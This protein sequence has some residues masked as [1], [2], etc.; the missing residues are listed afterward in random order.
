[1]LI[2]TGSF[3][4]ELEDALLEDLA[5]SG[6]P[7][8]IVPLAVVVP[9][10]HVRRYLKEVIT[11]ELGRSLLGVHLLTF[12][13]LALRMAQEGGEHSLEPA[14][15]RALE[16]LIALLLGQGD[17]PERLR[18]LRETS[19]G[20]RALRRTLRALGEARV[21]PDPKAKDPLLRLY[22]DYER[23][24]RERGLGTPA[25]VT[26]RAT[27][28]SSK[29]PFLASLRHLF[30]YGFYDLTQVQ[31]DFLEAVAAARPAT[32]YFPLRR[33]HPAFR[34]AERFL[35]RHLRGTVQA[36][37]SPAPETGKRMALASALERLF[38]E[39]VPAS[40]RKVPLKLIEV[41]GPE[42]ELRAV[43]K[44]IWRRVEEEGCR[45]DQIGVVARTLDPYL[46]ELDRVFREHAIPY[47]SSAVEPAG[48]HPKVRGVRLLAALL[49]GRFLREEVIGL[50]GSPFLKAET[51][52]GKGVSVRPDRW[53]AWTR[54]LGV[55]EGEGDWERLLRRA[56]GKGK[57]VGEEPLSLEDL[58]SLSRAVGFLMKETERFPR[59]GGWDIFVGRFEE[60]LLKVLDLDV[61]N[62]GERSASLRDSL[63]D[64][65]RSLRAMGQ[66]SREASRGEFLAALDRSLAD[67]A[68]PLGGEEG[69]RVLDAMAARSLKFRR[70]FVLGM[71]EKAFPRF[72]REDPF[73]RDGLRRELARRH[74]V[75]IPLQ[76]EGYDEEKL[77]FYLLLAG[78]AEEVVLCAQR[79][80]TEGKPLVP[81]WYRDELL[82]AVGSEVPV[83]SVPRRMEDWLGG[84]RSGYAPYLLTPREGRIQH[85]LRGGDPDS[86]LPHLRE[87]LR[88]VRELDAPDRHLGERDGVVGPLPWHAETFRGRGCSPTALKRY[89]EC[90]FQ[91]FARSV[92]ELEPLEEPERHLALDPP[93]TGELLHR[94]LEKFFREGSDCRLWSRERSPSPPEALRL[95]ERS[96][97]EVFEEYARSRPVG[98]PLGWSQSQ[99]TLLRLLRAYAEGICRELGGKDGF[100]PV[101]FEEEHRASFPDGKGVPEILRGR[102]IYG[103]IDRIDRRGERFRVVDYKF[104]WKSK[105]DVEQKN[106]E[107]AA[108]R[109]FNFQPPFYLL[110]AARAMEEEGCREGE[111]EFHY[112]APRWDEEEDR[113]VSFPSVSWGGALGR[114]VL[115]VLAQTLAGIEEGLFF[116]QPFDGE[117]G[118][119]ARCDFASICRKSHSAT[120]YRVEADARPHAHGAVRENE[121]PDD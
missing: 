71:T 68:L 28:V 113:I 33:K 121:V 40:G 94:V 89:A 4:P 120:R 79:S 3:H 57:A 112:L 49:R 111:V 73:L 18:G 30:Y 9:S 116:I 39:E 100:L 31:L 67:L 65:I 12:H 10:V 19:G 26:V 84:R 48:S 91:Y 37:A 76:L 15:P 43:A 60:L 6:R 93:Q 54:R 90:P 82:R 108:V 5:A 44:E 8:E 56:S 7:G 27:S 1:M 42:A 32:L 35:D 36:A 110:L 51:V 78:A 95:L 2:K 13:G 45:F 63:L 105:P 23:A 62:E 46:A 109:G 29:S 98:S 101:R 14:P 47:R 66:V 96:A 64:A 72:I 81:S 119:C 86:S 85:L 58:R 59:K 70:L 118:Y 102:P 97:R 117:K 34:F 25:D 53:D 61:E 114:R 24:R 75:R 104:T 88:V 69:V 80:D 77:L 87:G 52:A 17:Y 92:L 106:L 99:E 20:G 16:A 41:S 83:A 21:P 50:L 38:S 22:A 74:G 103:R 55:V 115:E 11:R 107:L